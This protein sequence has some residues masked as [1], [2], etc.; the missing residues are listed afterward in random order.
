M[1]KLLTIIAL[2]ILFVN[3]SQSTENPTIATLGFENC[4]PGSKIE[5]EENGVQVLAALDNI[6]IFAEKGKTT[7]KCLHLIGGENKS[8]ELVNTSGKSAKYLS[9]YAERW[10]SKLPFQ[11]SVEV[12]DGVN[13][14]KSYDGDKKV[15]TGNFPN[16]IFLS[17]PESTKQ[18]IRITATTA[19]SG[20]VLI[21]DIAFYSDAD[22][23]IDSIVAP[24]QVFP[25]LKGKKKNPVLNIQVFASGFSNG[26]ELEE[27]TVNTGGTKS[28]VSVKNVE[29][30]Y[31]GKSQKIGGSISFGEKRTIENTLTFLGKQKLS[32]GINNIFVSYELDDNADINSNVF[33]ECISLKINGESYNVSGSKNANNHLGIALRQHN[34]DDVDTY[35]IPG[36]ATTNKGTLIGVYDIRYN[37]G[38]DLQ[39]DVDVGMNRSTDGGQTWE[40]MKVIMD[41]GEWGGLPNDQNGI[42]DPSVLVDRETNTIWVAAVWAHGHPGQRNWWASRPGLAPKSTSQFVLVKSEDDGVTWSEPINITKQIKAKEWYLLLQGPGKGITLKD[43]TLVFPAQFKDKN[44]MPHSTIIYS[45]DHGKNWVI[46]TGAKSNT[47]EAQVIELNDGGL[48]LNMRDNRNGSDKSET[49]GRAVAVTYDFGKTWETHLTSNGALKEPTCMASLIKEDFVVNGELKSL[50]LFSNPNSKLGRHHIT[51]KVS[52]DD[53]E[54]WPEK[55]QLL[56]DSGGGRGYS[57][58]TKIDD[59]HVGILYEGSQADLI[60][61]K[62]SIEEILKGN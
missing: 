4:E 55:Y 24:Q 39:E 56:I 10:T 42:G 62:F 57:C 13:W 37:S 38:A 3:C 33:I 19:E 22:M 7:A 23:Q 40:P 44:E 52:V 14:R 32:H 17:L 30:F 59:K 47:T 58:M 12:F 20:G 43:G 15:K 51:I 25:I 48:M 60:F 9:F 11:F 8:F 54:T 6:Q 5:I 35:R 16:E 27:L 31:T 61:Q 49:N 41:M 46:G 50:V 1:N 53:G 45:K 28:S 18:R 26:L 29:V 2:A 21:D 34:D 36:L